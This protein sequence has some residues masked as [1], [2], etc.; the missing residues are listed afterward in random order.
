MAKITVD[1]SETTSKIKPLHG[2]GQPP[3]AGID[4]SYFKYLTN[5]GIPHSRLHDMGIDLLGGFVD[6]YRIFPD[7]NKDAND[8]A[9]YDFVFTDLLIEALVK[10]GVTPHWRLGVTIENYAHIK[11]YSI[12]PPSD[13]KKWAKI[14]ENIIRHYTEGWANGFCFDMKYWEI[15]NEP[16]NTNG[17]PT[18]PC[19]GGTKEGFFEFYTIVSK[20]LKS[21]FPDYMI[22]GY[23]SCGFYNIT[24]SDGSF[25]M[26]S[27][28]THYFIEFMDEFLTHI[29]KENAPLDFFSWH[30]YDPSI[31]YNR[32]YA[33]YARRRL[34]EEGFKNTLTDCNE[35]NC[36]VELRGTAKHAAITVSQMMVFQDEPVDTAAFYDARIGRSVY[37]SLFNPMTKEPLPAYYAFTAFNRLYTLGNE[38]LTTLDDNRLYALSASDGKSGAIVIANPSDS[39]IKLDIDLV[40]DAKAVKCYVTDLKGNDKPSSIPE[41][42]GKD[43]VISIIYDIV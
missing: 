3:C 26:C 11:A 1:F 20:H 18:N 39:Y 28:Q 38:C 23:G 31:E 33:R 24:G 30:S 32:L 16:D 37:G 22:G 25:G 17:V 14:S 9:S 41:Y 8:P 7:F 2:V 36:R 27:D 5:A 19:W 15:W 13:F 21:C 29:K 35:W 34:D 4:F 10:A 40:K 6:M 12:Y 42:I 43:T